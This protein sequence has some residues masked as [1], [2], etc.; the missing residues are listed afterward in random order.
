MKRNIRQIINDTS[1]ILEISGSLSPRLDAELL[2]A[3]V[4]NKDRSYFYMYPQKEIEDDIYL[5]FQT[6]IDKRK[7][8]VPLQY[9]I[10]KQEFMGLDFL[11]NQDVLIPRPDTEILVEN[12]LETIKQ[13]CQSPIRIL[14]IGSGSGAIGVSLAYHSSNAFVSC[15][16]ISVA[17]LKVATQNAV[18]HGVDDKVQFFEGDL[19]SPFKNEVFDMIV[20]NPPYIP[21]DTIASLQV[22]VSQYEPRT[23]LAGGK[24]GLDFYKRIIKGAPKYLHNGGYLFLEIGYNQGKDVTDLLLI[25]KVYKGIEVIKDLSGND[26][27]VKSQL[28]ID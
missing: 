21:D 27:V 23:A 24:D 11:V 3:F 13:S 16:D 1:Q 6:L 4:M 26:R 8:G 19:F 20:S 10:G 18:I 28:T 25:E 17:A 9:I 7:K 2:L 5:T 15:V 14:D 12:A 22:E